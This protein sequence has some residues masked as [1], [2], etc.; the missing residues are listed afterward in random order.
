MSTILPLPLAERYAHFRDVVFGGVE[1]RAALPGF[2]EAWSELDWQSLWFTGA[3]GTQFQSTDGQPVEIIDFGTWNSGPGPDFTAATIRVNGETRHGD[4]EL[5]TDVRDWEHHAHG[6][7]AD[8]DR[9]M[10]HLVLRMPETRFF[11]RTSQH[12]E[13]PQIV[14]NAAMLPSDAT[15]A[16]G[17]AAARL[18]R[19]ATPLATMEAGKVQSI[20]ESAAQFRLERKSRRLHRLVQAQGREQA[21]FQSLAQTLGYRNNQQPFVILAQRLPLRKMLRLEAP[22]REAML[23]GVSGFLEKIRV[24]DTEG[25]TRGYLRQLWSEWWRQRDACARWLESR[26]LPRWNLAATRPGNHPQRRLGALAAML[27]SWKRLCEPLAEATRWSQPAWKD[28]LAGLRHDYWTS[29]YTLTAA[30]AAKPLALIGETRMHEMLANVAYPLLVPERTRLWAEYLELPALLDNQKVRRALLRLFGES[31]P[32]A[33]AFN[34]KLH[35]HQGLLQIYEDFCLE[36]D[37]ACAACPF[38]ER[39]KEWA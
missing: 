25:V 1:D 11:T 18:G 27:A 37:S 5:D 6:S 36:D 10:L 19:C 8:Y 12:R 15:P 13:V 34:T 28:A 29:H 2:D 30:P 22:V 21:I 9:V 14:L 4:L 3:F 31:S 23:F 16:R 17:M 32:L 7:N 26:C 38:P 39:L 24:E 35:H 20:I 33:A